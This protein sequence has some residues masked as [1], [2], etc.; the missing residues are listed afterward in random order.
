MAVQSTEVLVVGAG[1]AGIAMSEHLARR[2]ID[3]L[4]LERARIA[5]RW[6][7]ERWDSLVANGPSWH[8]RFPGMT[9]PGA[10]DEFPAKEKVA[11][12]FAAYAQTIGA[13]VR[14]GVDVHEVRRNDVGPG[15]VAETSQGQVL[16]RYVVA[17]TGA[18]QVPKVPGIV[19]AGLGLTQLHSSAYRNP[20]QLP[21]GAVL[22]VG[23][24]SSGAQIAEELLRAGRRVFLSVSAH[25]RPPRAY[26]GRDNVWWLGVLNTWDSSTL[27][28]SDH[29][30]IAVSGARGGETVNFRQMAARG[31]VLVGRAERA[32][33]S[34]LHLAPTLV[35]D[36]ARGDADYLAMLDAADAYI[37]RNHLDL[38][39][40]PSAR[41]LGPQAECVDHPLDRLDLAAEGISS[42]IW[43]TGFAPDYSWAKLDAFAPDGKPLHQRGVS[44]E[45]GLYFLGLPYLSRRGSS[46]I[47]GVWHDAGFVAD[48]IAIKRAYLAYVPGP[49]PPL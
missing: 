4:V 39:P 27:P 29:V 40:E 36:L 9:Y 31:V 37:A 3:H 25:G 19:P 47:W 41:D 11:D 14:C 12:Y 8:D 38:P 34:A 24:G 32:E 43:A 1:Q 21:Q 23:S 7:T 30:T 46:F 13:P 44:T 26:R 28:G 16:A 33:G 18:F 49:R 10:Q 42:I 17:A 15:F 20:G 45:P 6:R 48:H 22:V 5:E 35:R 2:G